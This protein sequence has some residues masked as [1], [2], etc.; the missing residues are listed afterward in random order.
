MLPAQR[1]TVCLR[2]E[3]LSTTGVLGCHDNDPMKLL[4]PGSRRGAE[5]A[6]EKLQHERFF[7]DDETLLSGRL[8]DG[9]QGNVGVMECY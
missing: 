7:G 5:R 2:Q 3:V 8:P 9:L 1:V 6:P 4:Q